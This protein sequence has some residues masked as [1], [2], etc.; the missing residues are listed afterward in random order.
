MANIGGYMGYGEQWLDK[1]IQYLKQHYWMGNKEQLIKNTRHSFAGIFHKAR[2]LGLNRNLS[3]FRSKGTREFNLRDNPAKRPEVREKKSKQMIDFINNNPD[4]MLNRILKRNH[5]TSLEKRVKRIL[6]IHNISY[7][8]NHYVKTEHSYKFPDFRIK[9]LIIECDGKYHHQDK[10][11]EKM[12][13]RELIKSGYELLHFSEDKINKNI[14][15]VEKCILHKL[16]ELN[17]LQS[18]K[19]TIW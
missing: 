10:D 7:K 14:R 15:S 12:R 1:D 11:K 4:K 8:Y 18:N 3:Y 9:E 17:I 2:R 16:N 5:I 6:D 19:L 13:D